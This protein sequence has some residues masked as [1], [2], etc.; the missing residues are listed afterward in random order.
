MKAKLAV[1]VCAAASA[2]V[3]FGAIRAVT[4][5]AWD[6]KPDCWQMKRHEGKLAS[7]KKSGGAPVVFIGDSITHYWETKGKEQWAR[8]FAS[9][10]R[11]AINLGTSA[12]RT[13]HVLWRLTEGH[14]LEGYEAK[15]IVLMIGTNNTGH[16]PFEKE[17]PIDTIMGIKRILTVIRNRQPKARVILTAI[18]PRGADAKDPKRL[19]NDVV[20]KEI[21][22]F[23]DGKSVIWCDL[24][25]K[26]L[27]SEGRLSKD[28]FP[29]LLHPNA[30]G[31]QIWADAVVPLIDQVLAAAPDAVI[32]AVGPARPDPAAGGASVAATPVRGNNFWPG[33]YLDKRNEIVGGSGEYDLV[34]V[35]DSITHLWERKGGG[36]FELNEELK[37]TYSILNLGYCGDRT[38]HVLW[39]LTNGELEG[40]KAKAFTVMIGTNNGAKDVK[41]ISDGIGRIVKLIRE[42]H[43]ES[44][45]ILMPIFPRGAK[46]TDKYRVGNAEV[47]KLAKKFADGKSV[48]WLDFN[49]KFLEPDGTLSKRIMGDTVHPTAEGYRIWWDNMGPL[50]KEIVGK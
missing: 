17:P 23:A 50:V 27:D 38:E 31:Y 1:L 22:T 48:R 43:P 3:S 2:L 33:R 35:G 16:F 36:G 18:F 44:T 28:L 47:S 5:V 6:G 37:K 4:P 30:R 11:R 21:A 29:D 26:F 19:R 45:V 7:I 14:E 25:D 13:E 10:P 24:S 39:R 34:M 42:K 8:N 46:P 40:Y 41:A 32:P 49:D 9:D 12:D 20:N 15:C